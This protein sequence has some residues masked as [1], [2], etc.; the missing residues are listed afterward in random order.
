MVLCGGGG[1]DSRVGAGSGGDVGGVFVAV[2]ATDVVN[3]NGRPL[4]LARAEADRSAEEERRGGAS[5]TLSCAGIN[6]INCVIL[7][8]LISEVTA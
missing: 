3:R 6:T 1:D 5:A 8:Q 7:R 4:R 2:V